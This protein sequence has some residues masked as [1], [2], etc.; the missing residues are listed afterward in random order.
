MIREFEGTTPKI[1]PKTYVAKNTFRKFPFLRKE[2]YW[3][4][5]L[6]ANSYYV[7]S[8]GKVSSETI[9]KYINRV[10]NL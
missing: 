9:Q 2:E 8:A 4:E 7:G 1:H 3:G 5:E 10:E 6:W